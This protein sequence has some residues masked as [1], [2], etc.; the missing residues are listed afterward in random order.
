[1][2]G[3]SLVERAAKQALAAIVKG[4]GLQ[5]SSDPLC[6]TSYANGLPHFD[7][8]GNRPI[9][10]T[11]AAFRERLR[12]RDDTWRAQAGTPAASEGR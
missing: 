4:F 11:L 6:V 3:P 2:G 12:H 1:L 8:K 5:P 7:A 10:E 9:V